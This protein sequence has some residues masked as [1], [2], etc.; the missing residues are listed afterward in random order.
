MTA[1]K[2]IFAIVAF[3]FT[4]L[5]VLLFLAGCTRPEPIIKTVYVDVPV[6][7][8]CG[9]KTPARPKWPDSN[10]AL[11]MVIGI[12][13]QVALIMDGRRQRDAYI[14]IIEKALEGCTK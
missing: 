12:D 6:R 5:P 8:P 3:S 11:V 13:G 14:P 2:L 4:F 10:E 9:V 7:Q 1:R